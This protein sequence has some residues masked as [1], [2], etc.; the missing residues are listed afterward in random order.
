MNYNKQIQWIQL[1]RLAHLIVMF[2]VYIFML[3][4]FGFA[5]IR[6]PLRRLLF[7]QYFSYS[8]RSCI[9]SIITRLKTAF[10]DVVW[11]PIKFSNGI[12]II[13]RII[14]L[15]DGRKAM[16]QDKIVA[17]YQDGRLLKGV[18]A[19]LYWFCTTER[20]HWAP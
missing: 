10:K 2:L 6:T 5:I 16:I 20:H 11:F 3:L 17:H 8:Y 18:I 4:S 1:E 7:F 14:N 19:G 13:C 12:I 9:L 15:K